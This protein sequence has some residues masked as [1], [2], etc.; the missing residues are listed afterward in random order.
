ME[1]RV[2]RFSEDN[3]HN[4]STL[5]KVVRNVIVPPEYFVRKY[6]TEWT[7]LKYTGCFAFAPNGEVVAAYGML[8][9]FTIVNGK[10]VLIAQGLE[11]L[12]HPDHQRKGLYMMVSIAAH[13][14]VIANGVNMIYCFP[15]DKSLPG[16]VKQDFIKKENISHYTVKTACFPLYK[17]LTKFNFTKPLYYLYANFILSFFKAKNINTINVLVDQGYLGVQH[18]IDYINY[19]NFNKSWVVKIGNVT[20]WLTFDN[21][22]KIGDLTY[23]GDEKKLIKSLKRLASILGCHSYTVGFSPDTKIGNMFSKYGTYSEGI[24]ICYLNVTDI[25]DGADLKLTSADSDAF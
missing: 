10:R 7:G 15:N 5:F 12:T 20:V 3:M 24:H 1:Y 19:K 16:L 17:L 8:P 22:M 14:L 11:G 18:D 23:D 9:S 21:G 25:V 6:N 4:L 2:E 13:K